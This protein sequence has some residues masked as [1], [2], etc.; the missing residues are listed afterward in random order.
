MTINGILELVKNSKIRDHLLFFYSSSES[1]N[2]VASAFLEDGLDKGEAAAY[3][4]SEQSCERTRQALQPLISDMEEYERNGAFRIIDYTEWYIINGKFN[5]SKTINLFRNLLAESSQKGFKGLRYF[6]EMT[7]FFKHKIID[8]LIE[9][10]L[11]LHTT[12]DI[13][14][15]VTCAYNLQMISELGGPKAISMLFAMLKA[16]STALV[17]GPRTIIVKNVSS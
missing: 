3:V 14:M 6:G 11:A 7:C 13:N 17:T 10:E 9:Y 4:C 2:R 1:R 15:M 16:H 5:P 12:L 8:D